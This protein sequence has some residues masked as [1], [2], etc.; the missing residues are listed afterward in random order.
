MHINLSMVITVV[1]NNNNNIATLRRA[2][3]LENRWMDGKN[4]DDKN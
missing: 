1:Q 2:S 4:N 3:G